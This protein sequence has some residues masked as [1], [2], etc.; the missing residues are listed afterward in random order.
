[1][2][3]HGIRNLCVSQGIEAAQ[4]ESQNHI[5][6]RTQHRQLDSYFVDPF[7]S[8]TT[9]EQ[10]RV[11]EMQIWVMVRIPSGGPILGNYI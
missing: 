5:G 4:V 6:L 2:S 11:R 8:G 7:R 9:P 10:T 1:M 3:V